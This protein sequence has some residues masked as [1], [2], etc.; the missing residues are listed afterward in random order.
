MAAPISSHPPARPAVNCSGFGSRKNLV[1]SADRAMFPTTIGR[2]PGSW[3][4]RD[5]H[6]APSGEQGVIWAGARPTAMRLN[7]VVRFLARESDSWNR[8]FIVL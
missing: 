2:S 5:G 4:L 6:A 7:K 8:A 1:I 3:R